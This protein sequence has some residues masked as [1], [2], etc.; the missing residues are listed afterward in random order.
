MH[1]TLEYTCSNELTANWIPLDLAISISSS[2]AKGEDKDNWVTMD[3]KTGQVSVAKRMDRE[4][5]FVKNSTYNVIVYV[6]DNGKKH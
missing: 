2:F 4:S 5:P 1:S 3:P 6:V